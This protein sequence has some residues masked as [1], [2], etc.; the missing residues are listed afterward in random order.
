MTPGPMHQAAVALWSQESAELPEPAGRKT[1]R[2]AYA[3]PL[4]NST[5]DLALT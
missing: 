3:A 1:Y 4:D 5:V 2:R